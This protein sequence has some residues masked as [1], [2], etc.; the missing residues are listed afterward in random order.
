MTTQKLFKRRVRERMTKTGESYTAARRHV[1]VQRERHDESAAGLA[2]ARELASDEKLTAATGQA[3]QGWLSILDQWGARDHPH[4]EIARYLSAEHGVPG[5]WTQTITNGY[6]RARGIRAKHQ[7]SNGFTIYASRT[8]A[9]PLEV[10]FDAFVD[11]RIRETWLTDATASVRSIQQGKTAR[12][13]WADGGTRLLVSFEAK[14]PDKSTAHVA[15]ERLPDAATAEAAK[16]AW[17]RRLLTL[18]AVLESDR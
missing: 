10:L 8:V 12:F 14:G 7:Q 15:H 3:W 18:K 11:E 4:P 13:D 6:E 9:A 16:A 5:W 17:K 2:S 1:T